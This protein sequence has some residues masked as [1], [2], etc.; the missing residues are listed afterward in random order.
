[1]GAQRLSVTAVRY[2]RP[3]DLPRLAALDAAEGP[4][5][6]AGAAGAA[7]PPP[8]PDEERAMWRGWLLAVGRPV[9]GFAR[10][11]DL[12]GHL[13]LDRLLVHSRARRRG[14]GGMLL[15][16]AMGSVLDAGQD[17][18]AV[19]LRG[20]N[21][22][23][24]EWFARQGFAALSP[25][26][27]GLRPA[28]GAVTLV[29][30]LV[31][32]PVP[33]DA[34]SVIPIRDGPRGVEAFVQHRVS[35]MDFAAGAVVFPGG[36]V[37]PEDTSEGARLDL[38]AGLVARHAAAWAGTAFASLGD[39]ETAARTV[40]ATGVRELAEETGARVDPARL[41]P[42]DD[43]VTPAGYPRRFDVRFL[44][45]P[46]RG[47]EVE[48]FGHTTTEAHSSRW[49]PLTEI[50]A[51]CEAGELIL[52]PPT[53]CLVDELA[54]LGSVRSAVDL[55][56]VIGAVRHDI[57]APRPRPPGPAAGRPGAGRSGAAG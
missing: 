33:A 40:L 30:R 29:R 12:G 36:R 35:T 32:E 51:R 25:K 7:G 56:P 31:D 43:W 57:A 15:H 38:P 16:A 13:H 10:I 50:V 14:L 9:A 27:G 34:V 41:L 23:T 48:A 39:P 37:D 54:V 11:V 21:P 44:L 8:A 18:L 55:R 42:W 5:G 26:R 52:L 20:G 47:P 4:A 53:R 17:Q 6:A 46:V 22:A 28:G 24:V 49:R 45:L 19:T 2:A 1:M 3:E